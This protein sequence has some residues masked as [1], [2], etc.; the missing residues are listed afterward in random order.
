[1]EELKKFSFAFWRTDDGQLLNSF[2][3]GPEFGILGRIF[4]NGNDFESV[5]GDRVWDKADNVLK[6]GSE[7]ERKRGRERKREREGRG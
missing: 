1:M 2:N 5:D 4:R 6:G 7:G 3:S